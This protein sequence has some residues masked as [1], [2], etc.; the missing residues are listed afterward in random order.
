MSKEVLFKALRHED[1]ERAPWVPFS[2]VHS[3]KLKGY[4]AIEVLQDGDKLLESILEVNKVYSPDGQPVIFDLQ[5]EAEILGCELT[6]VNDSPPMVKTHPLAEEA[7][8]PCDCTIPTGIEGRLPMILD[9]MKKAKAKIG[10]T[11]ALYGLVC[12]PFTLASHLRGTDIFLD[13][14]EDEDYVKDLLEY[15]RKV[16]DKMA[17][18]YIEAGMD[19]IGFVDPLVSQI[20]PEHFEE[21]LHK[22]YFE[23]FESLRNKKVF[24][25]LFVCGDATKNI[26]V[27]CKTNP[28]NISIDENIDIKEAKKITDKYN[29]TIGGNIQLTI[30]MLHGSQQANMKAAIDIIDQ[31]GIKNLIVS[32]GCDMPYATPIE[33]P[34]AISQAVRNFEESKEMVKGFDTSLD[35]AGIDVELIDYDKLDKPLIE[36][37]TLD[38]ASCAACGYMLNAVKDI[39]DEI[40]DL[41]DYVEYKF[42]VKENIAR[43]MKIGVK[44]LPSLYINGKL[45]WSSLIPNRNELINA[46][47][48]VRNAKNI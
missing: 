35:L 41:F 6:W 11:T 36:L 44:N 2:G 39:Q 25:S 43:C 22:P 15:S 33:N 7:K 38:S 9:V 1:N 28:D 29:I 27:M 26:E 31:C 24:S 18:L 5:V 32:P 42:T 48:E 19:I 13:M 3:G 10:N 40:G 4:S 47:K 14:Y 12:G 8:I 21:F 34:I 46:I 23:L 17:C 30:T 20:S 16:C 45:Y 37:Y